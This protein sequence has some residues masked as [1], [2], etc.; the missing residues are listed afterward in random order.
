MGSISLAFDGAMD[1]DAAWLSALDLIQIFGIP[2]GMHL[3]IDWIQSNGINAGIL[4]IANDR[5]GSMVKMNFAAVNAFLD[6]NLLSGSDPTTGSVAAGR[7]TVTG[8]FMD[9]ARFFAIA[10][11]IPPAIGPLGWQVTGSLMFARDDDTDNWDTNI[12][13]HYESGEMDITIFGDSSG[14]IRQLTPRP[15]AGTEFYQMR[16]DVKSKRKAPQ[17]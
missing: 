4:W 14:D 16:E 5:K 13:F 9:F 6:R 3:V 17:P 2:E 8:P 7:R 12:G 1:S 10:T 11:Q 15:A